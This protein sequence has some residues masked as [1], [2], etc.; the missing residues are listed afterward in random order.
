MLDSLIS[1]FSYPFVRNAFIVGI[2]ISFCAALLG[3][4]LVLK[5]FSF[6][7]DGLSHFAFGV[8]AVAAVLGITN[9]ML[10]V[11]PVTVICA[12]ILLKTG[13]NTKIK[14]DA[15]VAMI[16][17]CSLAAGYLL[18][19]VFSSSANVA[20]DVCSTLFGSA[21]ILT[22]KKTDVLICFITALLIIGVF[23]FFYNRIFSVTFDEDFSNATGTKAKTYNTIIAVSAAV[24]VVLAMK[25]VGSLLISALIVIPALT[26]MSLFKS[27]KS[28]VICSAAVSVTGSAAGLILS[29]L[30]ETPAG[31]TVVV[32]D[33]IIFVIFNI[34]S[35]FKK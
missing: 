26:A 17:V 28:V 5:R 4:V 29:L 3:V 20:G 18:L 19:N 35:F 10:L 6:L 34:I 12:V 15:A 23:I 16:S 8:V 21:S 31:A 32:T 13:Q 24:I 11:L 27:F 2:L 14:G 22:L 33:I 1:Y 7:G 25:L 30:F 9:N